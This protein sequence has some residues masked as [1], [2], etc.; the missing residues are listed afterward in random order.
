METFVNV[1]FSVSSSSLEDLRK[2]AA[3]M[4]G[5]ELTLLQYFEIHLANLV[6]QFGPSAEY[7][8]MEVGQQ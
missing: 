5:S 1:K 6:S 4:S 2:V 3:Y 7:E 8:I